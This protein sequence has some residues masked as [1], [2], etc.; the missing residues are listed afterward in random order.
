MYY[1]SSGVLISALLVVGCGGSGSG[2]DFS[3]SDGFASYSG[4]TELAFLDEGNSSAFLSTLYG[5]G[6]DSPNLSFRTAGLDAT[7]GSS[8]RSLPNLSLSHI[9][10]SGVLQHQQRVVAVDEST[11]CDDGGKI[12]ITGDVDDVANTAKLHLD[13]VNCQIGGDIAN[14]KALALITVTGSFDELEE[15]TFSYH[16]LEL[17]S[18][19]TCLLY[20]SPSPRD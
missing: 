5:P 8:D 9:R 19:S 3:L 4:V 15:I 2:E 12:N 1:K 18:L 6:L 17:S 11:D 7:F 10:Q 16:G 14:G 13:Y 20:T